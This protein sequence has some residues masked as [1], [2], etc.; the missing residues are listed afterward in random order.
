MFV[1]NAANF[2]PVEQWNSLLAPFAVIGVI[3]TLVIVWYVREGRNAAL[4]QIVADGDF[5][6]ALKFDGTLVAEEDRRGEYLRLGRSTKKVR[7]WYFWYRWLAGVGEQAKFDK[8]E[9][10]SSRQQVAPGRKGNRHDIA[11]LE[12]VAIRMREIKAGKNG[13]S[14][15]NLELVTRDGKS[16]PFATSAGSY[17]RVSFENSAGVAKAASAIAGVSVQGYVAG[18]VWTP[19]WPPKSKAATTSEAI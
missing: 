16:L 8:V 10:D 2:L 18:N 5:G 13:R 14:A 17:R 19:G 12:V 9:L 7:D 15:W 6:T 1:T 11:F 3:V 4:G